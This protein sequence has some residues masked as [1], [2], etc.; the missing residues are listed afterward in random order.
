MKSQVVGQLPIINKDVSIIK[1]TSL[2]EHGQG[3]RLTEAVG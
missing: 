2:F 1:S 3:L